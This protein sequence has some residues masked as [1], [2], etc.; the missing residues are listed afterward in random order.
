MTKKKAEE[1]L[2]REGLN[3]FQRCDGGDPQKNHCL[4]ECG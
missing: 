2:K 3:W 4:R 1:R